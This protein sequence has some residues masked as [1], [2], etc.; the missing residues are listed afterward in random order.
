VKDTTDLEKEWKTYIASIPIE[1]PVARLKRGL[2]AVRQLEFKAAVEDLDAAIEGGTTDPRAYWARGR[3]LAA[4]G[5]RAEGRKDLEKAVEL[6]PLSAAFRYE[7]SRV[8]AGRFAKPATDPGSAP[9]AAEHAD[10]EEKK[11]KIP[12]ARTQA[13]L[14]AELDPENE[15][16]QKWFAAFEAD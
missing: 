3:A 15:A 13:G 7:L 16:F 1:G 10:V 6:D 2:S 4:L 14:A 12:E 9:P 5:K 11:L 8:I